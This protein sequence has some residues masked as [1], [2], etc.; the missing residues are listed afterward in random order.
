M[1][2]INPKDQRRSAGSEA[3]ARYGHW[4]D[5]LVRTRR[6]GCVGDQIVTRNTTSTSND[7]GK[8]S[9]GSRIVWAS[10]TF[11]EKT[12]PL[13][14]GQCKGQRIRFRAMIYVIGRSGQSADLGYT[15]ATVAQRRRHMCIGQDSSYKTL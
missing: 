9:T 4:A 6:E 10:S 3:I 5:I 15:M 2:Y 7:P 13:D 14:Q 12:E 8:D 11:G 1:G